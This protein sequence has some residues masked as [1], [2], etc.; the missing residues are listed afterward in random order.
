MANWDHTTGVLLLVSIVPRLTFVVKFHRLCVFCVGGSSLQI[1]QT[2]TGKMVKGG[3]RYHSM[4][5]DGK[6]VRNYLILLNNLLII[7]DGLFFWKA[8]TLFSSQFAHPISPEAET[9]NRDTCTSTGTM[10]TQVQSSLPEA[11]NFRRYPKYRTQPVC[12]PYRSQ[13]V[14]CLLFFFK[15]RSFEKS[16][17]CTLKALLQ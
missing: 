10:L 9:R 1:A 6:W 4:E 14:W 16:Q 15:A 8:S 2:H 13:C 3:K 17:E 11:F 7:W 5:N 12:E